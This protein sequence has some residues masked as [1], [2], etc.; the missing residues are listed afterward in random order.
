MENIALRYSQFMEWNTKIIG[1]R[2]T[3]LHND[4]RP[5]HVN[6]LK[7][8]PLIQKMLSSF[9]DKQADTE[10]GRPTSSTCLFHHL[11][12]GGVIPN[13]HEDCNVHDHLHAATYP[14]LQGC[15]VGNEVAGFKQVTTGPHKYHLN[16]AEENAS[17]RIRNRE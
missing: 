9:Y 2:H 1:V 12:I 6:A 8:V 16:T 3:R 11:R 14:K 17:I 15:R 13:L 10:R 7:E 4:C 5:S